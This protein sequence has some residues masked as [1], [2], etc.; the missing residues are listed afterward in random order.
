MTGVSLPGVSRD[1][2]AH[3]VRP[4]QSVT[5]HVDIGTASAEPVV[6]TVCVTLWCSPLDPAQQKVVGIATVD[7]P[8]G[9]PPASLGVAETDLPVR[10]DPK[11]EPIEGNSVAHGGL[12]VIVHDNA[13]GAG[14][15]EILLIFAS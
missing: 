10:I 9:V 2:L 6:A 3:Q 15:Q 4:G 5:V 13:G 1:G 14:A 12:S 11:C 8:G 7:V